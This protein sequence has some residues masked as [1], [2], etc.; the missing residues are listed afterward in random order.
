MDDDRTDIIARI[1][2]LRRLT[3]EARDEATASLA[4]KES[5]RAAAA[6]K[7][8]RRIFAEQQRAIEAYWTA[9]A[10]TS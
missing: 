6:F 5:E 3:E 1:A 10:R 8:E 9:R 7:K 2:E 4:R